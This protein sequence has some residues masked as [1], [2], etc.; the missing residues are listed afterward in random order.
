MNYQEANGKY[1][2]WVIVFVCFSL[3]FICNVIS[4]TVRNYDLFNKPDIECDRT[5]TT[6]PSDDVIIPLAVTSNDDTVVGIPISITEMKVG[7]IH[8]DSTHKVARYINVPIDGTPCI[9]PRIPRDKWL[10]EVTIAGKYN[11]VYVGTR[12]PWALPVGEDIQNLLYPY[13]MLYFSIP[14]DV[15]LDGKVDLIDVAKSKAVNGLEVTDTTCIYDV[16]CDNSIDLLDMAAI[17]DL[18]K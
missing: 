5:I 17:K 9:D 4:C 12:L 18:V 3:S 1:K 11:L 8:E 6:Q 14:G 13:G 15:N 2:V 10:Y 7:H 16:N